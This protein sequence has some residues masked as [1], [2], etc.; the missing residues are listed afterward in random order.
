MARTFRR[1]RDAHPIAELN[2]TN[3]IDV[4]FTLLII[5]MIA[6]PLIQLEQTIPVKLPSESKSPQS[7]PDPDLTFHSVWIDAQLRYYLDE[8][9]VPVSLDDLRSR[10]LGFAQ[11]RRKPVIRI[12]AD[13]SVPYGRVIQVID[14]LK[15]VDLLSITF[16]T[17]A[18]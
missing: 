4:A 1:K 7:P 17:Q 9:R 15:K 6:T 8:N 16:D 2:V 3:L 13:D 14:E 11:E 18:Q 10:L 5:F 12:R